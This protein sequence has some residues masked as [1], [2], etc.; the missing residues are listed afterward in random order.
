M[1]KFVAYCLLVLFIFS[2]SV[3]DDSAPQFY[4]EFLPIES[5]NL[6]DQFHFGDTYEITLTYIRPTSCYAFNSIYKEQV[7]NEITLAI[8]A[9]VALGTNNCE[10]LNEEM[11][12]SFNLTANRNGPYI[13]KLWQGQDNYM[14]IEVPVIE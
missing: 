13:F 6:P 14:I 8:V 3:S 11:E 1:K 10:S 9:N 7:V 2:C 12:I 4:N 5:T